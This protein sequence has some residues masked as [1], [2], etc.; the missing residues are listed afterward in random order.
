MNNYN[1]VSMKGGPNVSFHN[2]APVDIGEQDH[3]WKVIKN[4][5]INA[6]KSGAGNPHA[7]W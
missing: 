5:D 4:M 2:V 1:E 6:L 3:S 7:N